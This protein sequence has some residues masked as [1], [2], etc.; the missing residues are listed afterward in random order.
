MIP[1]RGCGRVLAAVS[2]MACAGCASTVAYTSGTANSLTTSGPFSLR[3]EVPA[4][5]A[6]G[7]PV[8]LR[9]VLKNITK[10]T[11]MVAMPDVV[12]LRTDYKVYRWSHRVWHKLWHRSGASAELQGPL[13]PNDSLMFTDFWPQ[14]T[15]H[16]VPVGPGKYTIIGTVHENGVTQATEGIVS[17]PVQVRVR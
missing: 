2:L 3:L 12:M 10:D 8:S 15:D 13:A 6:G 16:R 7:Q 9:L 5:V 11:L 17:A 1:S 14:R 4:V